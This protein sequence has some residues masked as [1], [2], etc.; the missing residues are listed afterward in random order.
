MGLAR[1]RTF[2]RALAAME[3]RDWETAAAEMLDSLWARQVG[4]RADRLARQML[5]GRWA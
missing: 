5:T 2:R 4:A 1:L 3:R